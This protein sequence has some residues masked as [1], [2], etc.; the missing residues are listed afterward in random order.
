[1]PRRLVLLSI[2]LIAYSL[3]S[4][5]Q[6]QDELAEEAALKELMG[7]Y[8][9][10]FSKDGLMALVTFWSHRAPDLNVGVQDASQVIE[11]GL[12][13]ISDLSI[14]QI[15]IAEGKA[16]LQSSAVFEFSKEQ[17]KTRQQERLVRNL[18]F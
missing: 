15:K 5:A 18:E 14:T 10:S 3:T 4:T 16:I 8:Y 12:A 1:V 11:K 9:A 2:A 6:L 17:T 7:R 13:S